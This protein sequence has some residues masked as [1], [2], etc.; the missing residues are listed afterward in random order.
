MAKVPKNRINLNYDHASSVAGPDYP[1]VH[2]TLHA[3][4]LKPSTSQIGPPTAAVICSWNSSAK[5]LIE[6]L[7][8]RFPEPHKTFIWL[9]FLGLLREDDEPSTTVPSVL[10]AMRAAQL[11]LLFVDKS[12]DVLQD[13]W[14]LAMMQ[15]AQNADLM[16]G[17]Q[18]V[19]ALHMLPDR[20]A[21]AVAATGVV[22]SFEVWI[23]AESHE[24][25]HNI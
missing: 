1:E 14:C 16:Q 12:A 5:V 7:R 11:H 15:I 8:A 4:F 20:V 6:A 25:S 22:W 24:A 9:D 3:G 18:K 19:D 13:A 17:H 23:T 21:N 2:S 10:S